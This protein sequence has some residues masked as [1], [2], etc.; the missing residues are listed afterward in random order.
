[1]PRRPE[2]GN[3]QVY[4]KRPLRASDRNGYVLKFYCPIAK[5]RI[6]RACGTRDRREAQRIRRECR[7]R[8]HNGKYV[9]SGGAI[10]AK[11][12]S[13]YQPIVRIPADSVSTGG[14]SWETCRDDYRHHRAVRIRSSSLVNALSRVDIAERIFKR[15][16]VEHGMPEVFA[17]TE[18]LNLPM[19]EYLQ[20]RLLAGELSRFPQRSV[21]TVNSI[22]AGVM[23]FVRFCQ[24]RGWIETV[25]PVQRLD[26]DGVM[27]GRPV[28]ADEFARMLDAVPTVVGPHH[29]ES[30]RFTLRVL[31]ESGF[32]VAD[33]M[34][35]SW[36]D[37]RHIR[38]N[39]TDRGHPTIM[40]PS[41]QKNGREQEV[42]MLPGLREL[43]ECIPPSQRAGWIVNPLTKEHVGR[44]DA[45]GFRPEA[46]E[47]CQLANRW[48][49][50]AIAKACDVSE[51]AVRIWLKEAG[52]VRRKT[53]VRSS[54]SIPDDVADAIRKRSTPAQRRRHGR[55]A[56]RLTKQRVGRIISMVGEE[57]GIVVIRE[58]DRSGKR[59]KF[60]SA[61][62][63]RRGC[64][65]RLINAGVSAETLKVVMRHR[66]FATTERHYGAI[67][68]AQAAAAEVHEKLAP[69][70]DNG[71]FVGGLMGGENKTPQLTAE[72]LQKLKALLSA[73]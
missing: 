15:Y 11:H 1:M 48:N 31:W 26:V 35:F 43:L 27:R 36:D 19:L 62:D 57:A 44:E 24:R 32:R 22:M 60:A 18:M 64:A 70:V 55:F 4:P 51:A 28:T 34:D 7:E 39:W 3:V 65:Q 8:L 69:R 47:L 23:T 37:E 50:C 52:F 16:R 10:T 53:S 20:D 17:V 59:R 25:P 29:A 12:E 21:N 13:S 38:P 40:I 58:D 56:N 71:A 73:I 2:I 41:T 42:P 46:S 72:E 68:S 9:D 6:R 5:T 61:H 14:R 67:R 49:N 33:V 63:L 54:G 66:D 45:M 30:W